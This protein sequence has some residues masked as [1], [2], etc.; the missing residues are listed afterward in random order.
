SPEQ[1]RG[2]RADHR[3]DI[4]SVGCILYNLISGEVPFESNTLMGV[5]TKHLLDPP[6]PPSQRRPDL[7]ITPVIDAIVLRAMEK[8]PAARFQTMKELFAAL[9][10]TSTDTP[11]DW[12][13][14]TSGRYAK[15]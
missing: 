1:G 10:G 7:G 5:I 12:P 9:E 8:D 3:A 14:P 2:D 6:V 15:L 13:D 4:Y 11:M